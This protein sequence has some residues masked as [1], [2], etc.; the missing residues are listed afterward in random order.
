MDVDCENEAMDDEEITATVSVL[1]GVMGNTVVLCSTIL[2][3]LQQVVVKATD[4]GV[5]FNLEGVVVCFTEDGVDETEGFRGL[6]L[7]LFWHFPSLRVL[8]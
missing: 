5:V 3:D 8:F 6:P 4:V 7:V 2:D 1:A